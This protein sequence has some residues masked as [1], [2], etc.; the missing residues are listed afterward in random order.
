MDNKLPTEIKELIEKHKTD[1]TTFEQVLAILEEKE[2]S[3]ED[4]AEAAK[5]WYGENP[6]E[7]LS[8]P[9][10]DQTSSPN[11]AET[12]QETIDAQNQAKTTA[13]QPQVLPTLEEATESIQT[14]SA[15]QEDPVPPKKHMK[16]HYL[17]NMTPPPVSIGVLG[18]VPASKIQQAPTPQQQNQQVPPVNNQPQQTQAP[19][20]PEIYNSL[21]VAKESPISFKLPKIVK[22]LLIPISL[23]LLFLLLS[24]PPLIAYEVLPSSRQVK[25]V[26]SKVVFALPFLPKTP[27]YILASTIQRHK[28][29]NSAKIVLKL[30]VNRKL[31]K[32]TLN[33]DADEL[34]VVG[35]FDYSDSKTGKLDTTITI[36]DKFEVNFRLINKN[37]YIKVNKIPAEFI[38]LMALDPNALGS[39]LNMWVVQQ[40]EGLDNNARILLSQEKQTQREELYTK[41]L[42]VYEEKIK[43]NI[44]MTTEEVDGF[45]VHRLHAELDK[46]TLTEI[47]NALKSPLDTEPATISNINAITIDL[48]IDKKEFFIRKLEVNP[49]FQNYFQGINP[50][51][52]GE[53]LESSASAN[54]TK[55]ST[56]ENSEVKLTVNLTSL[57]E[58]LTVEAPDESLTLDEFNE[59]LFLAIQVNQGSEAYL[60][61]KDLMSVWNQAVDDYFTTNSTY[62]TVISAV[63]VIPQDGTV[64]IE[65]LKDNAGIVLY[66][67]LANPSNAQK[68]YF[69]Y[70]KTGGLP[71][72]SKEYSA[73]ELETLTGLTSATLELQQIEQATPVTSANETSSQ[74]TTPVGNQETNSPFGTILN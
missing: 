10:F 40:F 45:S 6:P 47:E 56:P 25:A 65:S 53:N 14:Q 51:I 62:P 19:P 30:S 42:P 46:Q 35:G 61:S 11:L 58:P 18:D 28:D 21:Q 66:L 3:A 22:K 57:N 52:I 49:I 69:A 74:E 17:V 60:S 36:Q 32:D 67:K 43:P 34:A 68:P 20:Q 44:I 23:I 4:I 15:S 12:L 50:T 5:I 72:E 24:I 8:T 26:M 29:V 64:G 16:E 59:R 54:N 7:K 31:L 55:L 1:G 73:L 9:K 41:L 33:V 48:W 39:L 13:E 70:V 37:G 2:V 27:D 71:T 63:P 38:E